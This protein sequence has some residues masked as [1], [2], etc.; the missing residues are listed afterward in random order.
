M[1]DL[2][3]ERIRVSPV[4]L[5]IDSVWNGSWVSRLISVGIGAGSVMAVLELLSFVMGRGELIGSLLK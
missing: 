4:A 1:V 5:D 2:R 3:D